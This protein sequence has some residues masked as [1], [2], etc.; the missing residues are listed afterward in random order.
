M[1]KTSLIA[2][3]PLERETILSFFIYKFSNKFINLGGKNNKH[4]CYSEIVILT[5]KTIFLNNLDF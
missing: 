2:F 4:Q 1:L 3:M 5:C